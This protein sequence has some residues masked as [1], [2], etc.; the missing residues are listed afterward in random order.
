VAWPALAAVLLVLAAFWR[1]R[2]TWP[3]ATHAAG[4]ALPLAVA[5]AVTLGPPS[6]A[7][8]ASATSLAAL[9]AQPFSWPDPDRRGT[10]LHLL[11]WP[12][13]LVIGEERAVRVVAAVAAASGLLLGYALFRSAAL[14]PFASLIGQAALPVVP[15]IA[16]GVGRTLFV[17]ALP[18]ALDLLLLAHLVRRL[19]HLEGARDNAGAFA[20]LL[21]AQAPGPVSTLEVGLLVVVL[22]LTES[23]TG[24]R[25]RAVR[26]AMCWVVAAAMVLLF[27]YAPAWLDRPTS[28][29]RSPEGPLAEPAA[30][31]VGATLAGVALW[32]LPRSTL[33]P[34]VL[35]AALVAGLLARL[36]GRGTGME[37]GSGPLPG[38]GLVAPAAAAGMAAVSAWIR[39][40]KTGA[41]APGSRS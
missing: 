34:R 17:H 9:R 16:L 41:A 38:L 15:V 19:G 13:A 40:P 29:L 7:A 5:L 4:L 33:A 2:R 28:P 39:S 20:Y 24:G 31:A 22:A 21:L 32:L 12:A 36:V 26:L 10:V 23:V 18:Q 27:R 14:A 8:H 11:A 35:G 25:R 30:L 37:S 6:P 1:M 3:D